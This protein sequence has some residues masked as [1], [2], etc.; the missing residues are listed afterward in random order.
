MKKILIALCLSFLTV[1]SFGQNTQTSIAIIPEPVSITQ[2]NG[3]FTL[4]QNVVIEAGSQPEMKQVVAFLKDRLS[5][6]TGRQVTVNASAPSATIKLLLN[7]KADATLGKEGYQLSVKPDAIE[8]KANQAAGLYYGV[9]S[10]VQLF[11]AAIESKTKVDNIAW[12]A[13]CVEITDYPRFGWRGLMFDVSRHFFTKEEVKTYI[14]NMVRYKYNLL[15]LH[16]TDDEGWRIEIKSLPKLTTVGAWR[17]KREGK[18]GNTEAADP[19]E[20]KTYG[21]FY[22]HDDLREII[23][24]AQDRFVNVLPEVDVPGHSM[25]AVAAYPELSCTPG[26]YAVRVGEKI[27]NWHDKGFDAIID[28]TL[29]PA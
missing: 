13:P 17:A 8:I 5:I 23:K 22:T 1:A 27:M 6:P 21:G 28:N 14:D 16:L 10:L 7:Q 2:T 24:Y 20:P 18:W 15:H 29:C 9:Q 12:E 4:P 19:D 3:K 25:A 11:P 26:K